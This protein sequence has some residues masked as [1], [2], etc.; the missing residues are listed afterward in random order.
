[1]SGVMDHWK[2]EP[3]DTMLACRQTYRTYPHREQ[4]EVQKRLSWLFGNNCCV[5]P[6]EKYYNT[7]KDWY[8]T[9]RS[10]TPPVASYNY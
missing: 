6:I 1:M 10:L 3:R 2:L 8:H 9:K 4:M 5:Y 7:P